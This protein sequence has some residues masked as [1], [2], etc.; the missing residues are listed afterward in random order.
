MCGDEYH[1]M[2]SA[3]F[4]RV[5]VIETAINI[6]GGIGTYSGVLSNLPT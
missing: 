4:V 2:K 6:G 1:R 5:M 3:F